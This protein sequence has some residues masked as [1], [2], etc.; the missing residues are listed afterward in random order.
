[1]SKSLIITA[2]DFGICEATNEAIQELAD[3]GRIT[4]TS[5][6]LPGKAVE[7]AAERARNMG[8]VGI[9]LHVTLTSDFPAEKWKSNAPTEMAG[10]MVDAE[11][12][13]HS[14][15]KELCDG[16]NSAWV[17]TELA[18]QYEEGES[19]GITF[20]HL[21]SHRGALYG[22]TSK[23]FL[24]I[25]FHFCATNHLV[26]RFPKRLE[27]MEKMIGNTLHE[28]LKKA[29]SK[30]VQFAHAKKVKLPDFVM[31]HPDSVKEIQS[32]DQLKQYYLNLLRQLP[33]GVTEIFL[34][35]S[36]ETSEYFDESGEWQKRVW[37]YRFLMDDDFLQT[38]DEEGIT[39]ATW[40]EAFAC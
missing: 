37:E 20:D 36:K 28:T 10:P 17:I 34:H 7:D 11:G 23:S 38:L 22:L 2:D 39:L 5:L 18:A 40:K 4:A 26:F 31:S 9:G 3:N 30:G 24:Q 1:M 12:C 19:L 13:F 15:V 14:T 32:Y 16:A 21:D 6:I 8:N 25:V 27:G 29:H 35:P 33:E